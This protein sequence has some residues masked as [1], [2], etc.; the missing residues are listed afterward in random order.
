MMLKDE[1]VENYIT[2]LASKKPVPGGGGTSALTAALGVALGHMVGSFTMGKKKYVEV[3]ADIQALMV[4][5]QGLE[6]RLIACIDRDAEAF[7]PLSRAYGLP[8]ET[9]EEKTY[10]AKVMEECLKNAASVPME[11]LKECAEAVEVLEEF[12][13]KGS[14]LMLS[15]AGVGAALVG[16]AMESASLNVYINTKLMKDRAYAERMNEEAHELLLVYT[17]RAD[18]VFKK[19]ENKITG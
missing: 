14:T 15:D 18:A 5:A 7:E 12:A 8:K 3:E 17:G 16:A 19:V 9:E 13:E 4:R 6:Q 10:K 11:I 1:S 2:L